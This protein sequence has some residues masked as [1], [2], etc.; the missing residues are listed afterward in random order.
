[1]VDQTGQ[2][3][4]QDAY[5]CPIEPTRETKPR[6]KL[7]LPK[8]GATLA[9]HECKKTVKKLVLGVLIVST[10]SKASRKQEGRFSGS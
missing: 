3:S 9:S 6:W 10:W 2:K 1:M 7:V 8:A 4:K 5:H